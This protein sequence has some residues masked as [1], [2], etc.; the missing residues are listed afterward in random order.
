MPLDPGEKLTGVLSRCVRTPVRSLAI[1]SCALL[2]AGCQTDGTSGNQPDW[3]W[4]PLFR[5]EPQTSTSRSASEPPALLSLFQP[6]PPA[7]Q[8]APAEEVIITSPAI[9]PREDRVLIVQIQLDILRIRVPKG[10]FSASGKVWNHLDE[11]AIPASTSSLLRRNGMRVGLGGPTSWSPIRAMLE[12]EKKIETSSTGLRLADG[13]PLTI[14]VDNHRMRDQTL[15]LYRADGTMPG[16]TCP[17]STNLIRIE[18][19]LAIDRRDAVQLDI[20]PEIR[21]RQVIGE[22]TVND[23]RIERPVQEPTRVLRELAFSIVVPPEHFVALG[24]SDLAWQGHLAGSLLMNETIDGVA[25]E[26]MY[27]LTPKLYRS[28]RQ[29]APR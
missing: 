26:S 29:L 6:K 9:T 2:L 16:V 27:F 5:T 28:E 13:L 4:G 22:L 23:G 11:N 15:F 8:T 10:V 20:M 12:R 14:D 21:Q 17:M 3:S 18:Y 7:T 19:N 24:P 25:Y 1:A